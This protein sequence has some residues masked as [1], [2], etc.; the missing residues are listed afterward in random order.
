MDAGIDMTNRKAYNIWT[1]AGLRSM[2]IVGAAC[3]LD[4]VTLL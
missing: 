1:V 3:M 4:H 2:G